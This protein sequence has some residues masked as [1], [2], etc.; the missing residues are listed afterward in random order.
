MHLLENVKA[1]ADAF[2][3][4]LLGSQYP[5]ILPLLGFQASLLRYFLVRLGFFRAV[6]PVMPLMLD[7]RLANALSG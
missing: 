4:E 5:L 7:A 1:S 3:L 6:V 2:K